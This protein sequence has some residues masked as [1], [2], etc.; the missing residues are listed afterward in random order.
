MGMGTIH[1]H[2]TMASIPLPCSRPSALLLGSALLTPGSQLSLLSPP[3]PSSPCSHP[4]SQHSHPLILLQQL[5]TPLTLASQLSTPHPLTLSPYQLSP[6]HPTSSR[7][8]T[9]GPSSSL[10]LPPSHSLA[11]AVVDVSLIALFSPF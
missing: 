4:Q 9:L 10:R 2:P 1:V 7:P 5:C 8:L 11:V 6:S 3:A